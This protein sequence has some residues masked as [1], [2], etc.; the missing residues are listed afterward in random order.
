MPVPIRSLLGLLML[1]VV[2]ATDGDSNF[3]LEP[4]SIGR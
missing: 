1:G 4:G 2:C 3:I